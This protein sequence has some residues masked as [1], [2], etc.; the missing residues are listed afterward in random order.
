MECPICYDTIKIPYSLRGC[1]HTI[2]LG[3]SEKMRKTCCVKSPF[4]HNITVLLH[5]PSMTP[6]EIELEFLNR[7]DMEGIL[8]REE[9]NNQIRKQYT[10]LT[11]PL[12]RTPEPI[13]YDME[14][15]RKQFPDE[16]GFW[17]STELRWSGN[18][19]YHH[20]VNTICN[21]YGTKRH[22][23]VNIRG[24]YKG[25][26]VSKNDAWN[27]NRSIEYNVVD[28]KYL[29]K[30]QVYE[31]KKSKHRFIKSSRLNNYG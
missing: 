13:K 26:V 6:R 8:R 1:C 20:T 17:L 4:S 19:G 27:Y 23:R 18:Y 3:C 25:D 22:N 11:C 24:F 9:E 10:S 21:G 12:C 2:C 29:F 31:Y 14:V 5:R 28:H 30:E 16:Y 7:S 15:L